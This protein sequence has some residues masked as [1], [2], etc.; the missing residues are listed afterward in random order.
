LVVDRINDTEEIV[1]KPLGK[2]LKGIE[3]FAGATIMGDGDVALILDVLGLAQRA[4]VVAEVH[5]R[6]MSDGSKSASAA[7]DKQRLLLFEVGDR[8][9]MAIPL[10]LVARLEQLPLSMVERSSNRSV[11]QYRGQ[12]MPLIQ[13]ADY[14]DCGKDPEAASEDPMHVVVYSENG[15]SVGLVVG[16]ITDVVDECLTIRN[17]NCPEGILG[18]AVIQQ[19]VTDLP[20]LHHI[21]Q[22]AE[23]QFFAHQPNPDP[24]LCLT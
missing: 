24:A 19:R 2:H 3:C 15:R 21:I 1:V 23:P 10:S 16:R 14:L 6:P 13:V 4:K 5:E 12:I 9:R 11:V 8:G 18:S 22:A 17:D 7:E 20:D